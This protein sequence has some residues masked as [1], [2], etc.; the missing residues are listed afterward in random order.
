MRITAAF[1]LI[2]LAACGPYDYD[3]TE[4]RARH[5]EWEPLCKYDEIV[6]DGKCRKMTDEELKAAACFLSVFAPIR[7]GQKQDLIDANCKD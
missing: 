7:D 6:E 2:I 1:A 4:I 5:P 3:P